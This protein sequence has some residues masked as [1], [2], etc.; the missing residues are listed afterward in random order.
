MPDGER[1]ADQ[2]VT[3]SIKA[4][5]AINIG[6]RHAEFGLY[7]GFAVKL[8]SLSG[9]TDGLVGADFTIELGGRCVQGPQVRQGIGR[10]V[11]PIL[12]VKDWSRAVGPLDYNYYH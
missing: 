10:R 6:Q 8:R 9:D 12:T 2:R 11:A 4:E 1:A 7:H 5:R 3:L